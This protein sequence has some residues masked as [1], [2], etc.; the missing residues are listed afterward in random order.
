M[1][2]LNFDGPVDHFV[3]GLVNHDGGMR[4][5]HDF[6]DLVAAGS[7][8]EGNHTFGYE[9]DNRKRLLFDFFE[10]LVDVA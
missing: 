6:V 4:F 5:L 10:D 7:D 9:N 8:K 2:A 1:I 3:D